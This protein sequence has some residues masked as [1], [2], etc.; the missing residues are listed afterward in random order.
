M[1]QLIPFFLFLTCPFSAGYVRYTVKVIGKTKPIEVKLKDRNGT[2]VASNGALSGV[3]TI[4]NVTLWWPYTMS[5]NAGYRYTLQVRDS[6][7]TLLGGFSIS[8]GEYFFTSHILLTQLLHSRGCA[9]KVGLLDVN[10]ID[11]SVAQH[12]CSNKRTC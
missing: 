12:V 5:T 3:L 11:G 1:M 10:F 4:S 6:I 9:V 2:E 7:S 8:F